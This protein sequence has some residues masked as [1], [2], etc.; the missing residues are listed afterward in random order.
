M[1][2]T[3][4]D[5]CYR[6]LRIA[7]AIHSEDRDSFRKAVRLT[8]TLWGG[9]FNPIVMADRPEEAKHIVDVFRADLVW[10]VGDAA[11]V[12]NFPKEFPHLIVP[13]IPAKL[14]LPEKDR[15][16]RAHLLDIHNMLAH[17]QH[18]PG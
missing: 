3:R 12:N 9:R 2:T 8:H 7:W 15:P 4:V 5:I 1:D 13:F 10:P 11:V 18:T 16:T 6:P 17:C 14:F